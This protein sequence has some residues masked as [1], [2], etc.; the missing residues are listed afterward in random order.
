MASFMPTF[1][2]SELTCEVTEGSLEEQDLP[3]EL[4]SKYQYIFVV[5]RSASMGLENRMQITIDALILFIQ[6]LP[7]GC[8]FGILSFG[9]DIEWSFD[10]TDYNNASKEKAIQ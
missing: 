6:S 1:T 9:S 4:E 2:N 5:D 10:I 7:S 8:K 3:K